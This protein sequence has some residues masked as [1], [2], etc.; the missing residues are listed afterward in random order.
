MGGLTLLEERVHGQLLL[1][2]RLDRTRLGQGLDHLDGPME[3]TELTRKTG[4]TD[5]QR[6]T[7]H[8]TKEPERTNAVMKG[9]GSATE[10]GVERVDMMASVYGIK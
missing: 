6:A 4:R 7:Q 10:L 8:A 3:L 5:V 1:V 9:D 2:A